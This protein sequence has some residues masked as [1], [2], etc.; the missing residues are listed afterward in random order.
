M[1]RQST[2]YY[3]V[4]RHNYIGT[5]TS[6]MQW[7]LSDESIIQNLS[8]HT[9]EWRTEVISWGYLSDMIWW[10][11]GA[12]VKQVSCYENK[13][14]TE[15]V[16]SDQTE[17]SQNRR[18][19]AQNVCETSD[20]VDQKILNFIQTCGAYRIEACNKESRGIG[21]GNSRGS[22][23]LEGWRCIWRVNEEIRVLRVQRE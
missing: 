13:A 12:T 6:H 22:L 7:R 18:S 8:S 3:T 20:I 4:P 9:T 23:R 21:C 5:H 15:Y 14:S 2:S 16:R 17:H 10:D 1:P 11:D 19:R